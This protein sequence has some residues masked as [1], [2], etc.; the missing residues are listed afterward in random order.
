VDPEKFGDPPYQHW[1]ETRDWDL[2]QDQAIPEITLDHQQRV[3][4]F[5]PGAEKVV[6]A[7]LNSVKTGPSSS[8][9]VARHLS[10]KCQLRFGILLAEL[11]RSM[12]PSKKRRPVRTNPS[13]AILLKNKSDARKG[14]W[15]FLTGSKGGY[16]TTT[17]QFLLK[18]DET[19]LSKLDVQVSCTCNSW[20]FWGGQYNANE[21]HYLYGPLSIHAPFGNP[22]YPV[23]IDPP[24]K[25]DPRGEFLACKHIVSC[26]PLV[27]RLKLDLSEVSERILEKRREELTREP[28]RKVVELP[29]EMKKK[30]AR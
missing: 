14:L 10:S 24:K 2:A 25:R 4:N 21:R 15:V 23:T 6:Q 27:L 17:F 16:Y 7:Y 1:Y 9:V 22:N 30:V 8:V 29:E 3:R 26:I 18:G 28:E 19:D 12:L 13:G 5:K 11:E 20:I